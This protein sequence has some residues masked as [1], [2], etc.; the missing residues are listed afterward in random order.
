MKKTEKQPEGIKIRFDD[1]KAWYLLPPQGLKEKQ[2]FFGH[3]HEGSKLRDKSA[4]RKRKEGRNNSKIRITGFEGIFRYLSEPY[5]YRVKVDRSSR[6]EKSEDGHFWFTS[7]VTVMASLNCWDLFSEFGNRFTG[8]INLDG[9]P[10]IPE[11][12]VFPTVLHGDL[13]LSHCEL[14]AKIRL[15]QVIEGE[16]MIQ[17]CNIPPTWKMPLRID[18]LHLLGSSFYSNLDFRSMTLQELHIVNCLHPPR[19]KW[20][21]VFPGRFTISNEKISNPD[22]FPEE[23]SDLMV[24]DSSLEKD[25]LLPKIIHNSLT[26]CK[27]EFGPNVSMPLKCKVLQA[28]ETRFPVDFSFPAGLQQIEL[29]LCKLPENFRL[30]GAKPVH[31]IFNEMKLIK[32]LIYINLSSG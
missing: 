10:Y 22:F 14:P 1:D 16:F 30:P 4:F 15:P 28:L 3:L 18:C 17:E 19:L 8:D 31:L 23:V 11:R 29:I 7:R 20:P 6:V 13:T 2:E 27:V 25:A 32:C 9:Q 24:S 21:R 5:V 26:L 12:L